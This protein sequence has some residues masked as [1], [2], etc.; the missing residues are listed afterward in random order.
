MRDAG[1]TGKGC[2]T[3]GVYWHH[4]YRKGFDTLKRDP[5]RLDEKIRPNVRVEAL[6]EALKGGTRRIM[7]REAVKREK[8]KDEGQ[9]G[10]IWSCSYRESDIYMC[11][12]G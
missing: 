3:V 4:V 11:R 9:R 6:G 8:R 7:I 2:V 1:D 5:V 10:R 12:D